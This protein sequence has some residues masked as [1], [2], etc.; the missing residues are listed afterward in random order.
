MNARSSSGFGTWPWGLLTSA[1]TWA[2]FL[3]GIAAP[4]TVTASPPAADS[5]LF[6][7]MSLGSA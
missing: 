1:V 7:R 2:G 6:N 5:L 4:G 3:F